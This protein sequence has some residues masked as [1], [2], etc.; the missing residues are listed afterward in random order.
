MLR[1]CS[2]EKVTLSKQGL[3]DASMPLFCDFNVTLTLSEVSDCLVA[4][5]TAGTP[6]TVRVFPVPPAWGPTTQAFEET[7][8]S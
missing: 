7:Q 3:V 2:G 5:S 8:A 1:C 6:G 4:L